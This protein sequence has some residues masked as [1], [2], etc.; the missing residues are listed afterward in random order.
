M[1][2]K[3]TAQ[4][5][6]PQVADRVNGWLKD[7][8]L[9]YYLEQDSL[10]PEI[11]NALRRAPSKR[12]GEGGNRVDC[13]LLLQDEHLRHI[14]VMIEYKGYA[15]KLVKLN[16]DGYVHNF[17]K[18]EPSNYINDYAVNGAVHY[19]NAILQHSTYKEVVAIG[20]TGHKDE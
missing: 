13:K 5:V 20:V 15:D 16:A 11:D 12:G 1:A 17:E 3:K 6:E 10:N 2:K 4:S 18:G 14:P 8:G 7:Y 9:T 19:A